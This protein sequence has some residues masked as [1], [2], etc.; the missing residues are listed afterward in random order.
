MNYKPPKPLI[1]KKEKTEINDKEKINKK[2]LIKSSSYSDLLR[3]KM[4]IKFN[5]SKN[6]REKQ[7]ESKENEFDKNII[8]FRLPLINL[9][10]KYRKINKSFE[11]DK[12]NNEN[13]EL[14][15]DYLNQRRIIN[16]QNREKKRNNGE[17]STID[18]KANDIKK[19]IKENGFNENVLKMAKSKLETLE[20]KKNQKSLL[21]KLNGGV[22]NKPELGEEI[23][24]LII[25]SI[26]ARL[27]IIKEFEN[28]NENNNENDVNDEE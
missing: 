16:E 26:Q 28:V 15:T 22:A 20:E 11:K 18:S 12:N 17:L 27:S 1:I 19:L 21:L 25:D 5:T 24:D 6:K 13:H 2:G 23:C 10:E 9:K 8:N 7:I 4:L 14:T 3:K